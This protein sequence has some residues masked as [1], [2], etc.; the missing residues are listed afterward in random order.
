M[1][2]HTKKEFILK[3]CN[4][5]RQESFEVAK[6]EINMLQKYSGPYI[7]ELIDSTIIQKTRSSREALLLMEYYPGGHLLDRLLRRAGNHLSLEGIFR[8][9][10]QLCLALRP[11]HMSSPPIAHRDIKL[12]N[13]LFGTVRIACLIYKFKF[14]FDTLTTRTEKYVYVISVHA[15]KFLFTYVMLK[16]DKLRK[17]V[18]LKRQRKVIELQRWWIYICG[19]YLLRR[20]IFGH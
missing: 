19:K 6:K 13:I 1:E 7:V 5:D 18:L 9:F 20:P 8:I 10:G 11:F 16:S 3:R 14:D 2:V 12:E 4:I 15:L 17:S